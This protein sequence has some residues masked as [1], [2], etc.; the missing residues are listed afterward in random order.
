MAQL[1]EYLNIVL[2][3]LG[4]S[5]FGIVID[6]PEKFIDFLEEHKEFNF[7]PGPDLF[8]DGDERANMWDS[9]VEGLEIYHVCCKKGCVISLDSSKH[10]K[11]R[12]G[13]KI[14]YFEEDFANLSDLEKRLNNAGFNCKIGILAKCCGCS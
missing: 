9:S 6:N 3:N 13:Q 14:S 5:T 7:I 10:K 11:K 4:E 12:Y 1:L 2:N 8:V